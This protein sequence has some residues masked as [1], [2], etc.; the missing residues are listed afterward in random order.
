VATCRPSVQKICTSRPAASS[1]DFTSSEGY[2]KPAVFRM[3]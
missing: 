1:V 3:P 2:Q